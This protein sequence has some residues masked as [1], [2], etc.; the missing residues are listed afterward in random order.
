MLVVRNAVEPFP[1]AKGS[2]TRTS[3]SSPSSPSSAHLL[4]EVRAQE[5][6]LAEDRKRRGLLRPNVEQILRRTHHDERPANPKRSRKPLCFSS[7]FP[8][9]D[10]YRKTWRAWVA[11]YRA[12]SEAFRAGVLDV[13]FPARALPPR[14]T[15][16]PTEAAA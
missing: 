15:R 2:P 6:A 16:P 3:S 1:G 12:A 11:A 5:A 8:I 14:L 9:A 10:A 7:S 4:S 13:M